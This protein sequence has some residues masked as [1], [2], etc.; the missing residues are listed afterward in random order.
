MTDHDHRNS[1]TELTDEEVRV[2]IR[3]R[4]SKLAMEKLRIRIGAAAGVV[5]LFIATVAI[6]VQDNNIGALLGIGIMALGSG[7]ATV[8]QIKDF[9]GTFF[10][11]G[12][13]S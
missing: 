7:I 11:R 2:A 8:G 6:L 10:G 3:E 13:S 4:Q 5:G 12:G 1:D 9:V